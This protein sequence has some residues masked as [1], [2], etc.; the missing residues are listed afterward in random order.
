MSKKPRKKP[1][2]N[3]RTKSRL[4][5]D[6]QQRKALLIGASVIGVLIVMIVGYGLL[7]QLVLKNNRAVAR[8]G[9]DAIT[10]S[11]FQK[12]A[13]YARFQLIQQYN[14]TIQTYQMFA[15]DE[16]MGQYF[17]SQLEQIQA[18][19]NDP[20]TLG[21]GVVTRL[22]EDVVIA[23]E[24]DRLG[25]SL[26]E[27]DI[28]QELEQAFGFYANGTPTPAATATPF[29]TATLSEAQIA[30]VTLTPTP[31][32]T[33]EPTAAEEEEATS[34]EGEEAPPEE[35]PTSTPAPTSTP[36]T[37]EGFQER[38][39]EY[40]GS[41]DEINFTED[42][43]RSLVVTFIL[44]ERVQEALTADIMPEEEQ[45]WARHIL[46][47]TEEEALSVLDRLESGEDWA[48]LA[49]E[50]SL[51]TSNKDRGGDL[52]W[53]SSGQMVP[54]FEE[55]AFTLELGEIS[56]PIGTDFGYHI[57]QSLGKDV[58]PLSPSAF[59]SKRDQ[60]FA[61]WLNEAV[62]A[63]NVERFDDL[64]MSLVPTEPAIEYQLAP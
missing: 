58:R 26:S 9:E 31:P 51:D 6:N 15:G 1:I 57:I 25:I 16:T 62:N 4:E 63:D 40:T 60:V 38:L 24:A 29:T 43:L 3:R 53:F 7:D 49:A 17:N 61:E 55:A 64:W 33:T 20:I 56:G 22:I 13:R 12:Q 37:Q 2:E 42:N 10:V 23:Q 27:A 21:D 48:N 47:E 45:V 52:G 50:L 54:P 18:Q 19:L 41:L 11:D 8:V 28:Q 44:R 59:Q 39:A 32:P 5:Q 34:A 30:L 36:Y 35:L 46:V 14:N